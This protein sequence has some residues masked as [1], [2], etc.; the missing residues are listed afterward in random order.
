M[1]IKN[2][3]EGD[4]WEHHSGLLYRVVRVEKKGNAYLAEL[5]RI[6]GREIKRKRHVREVNHNQDWKLVLMRPLSP[7]T[8][9]ARRVPHPTSLLKA[10]Q[11]RP[12][13]PT[14]ARIAHA[15]RVPKTKR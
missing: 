7:E 13:I 9:E 3:E 6:G 15:I 4:I 10:E 14:K 8:I 11:D 12:V 5:E 2:F 1:D